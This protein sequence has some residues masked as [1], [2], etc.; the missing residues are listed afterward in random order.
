MS[1]I[2]NDFQKFNLSKIIYFDSIDISNSSKLHP[3][4]LQYKI[5]IAN[6]NI[7]TTIFLFK[8]NL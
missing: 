8:K 1:R 4:D 7:E 6:C 5:P 3:E 2:F